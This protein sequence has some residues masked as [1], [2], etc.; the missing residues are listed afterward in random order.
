LHLVSAN[1]D[2]DALAHGLESIRT[3]AVR[4]AT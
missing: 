4:T 1:L 2:I 3:R